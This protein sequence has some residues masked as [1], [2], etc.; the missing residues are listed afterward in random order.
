M[1]FDFEEVNGYSHIHG[2]D[3]THV[4]DVRTDTITKP[5]A[6]MRTAMAVA[7]VGDSVFGEDPTVNELE[8]RCA[9]LLGKEDAVYLPSGTMCNLIAIMVH[10]NKRGVEFIAGDK[11]HT[12]LFEQG[13][14]A[15]L[16][17]VQC[18]LIPNNPDGTFSLQEVE[19]RIRINTDYHEPS[20]ALI[21]V[22]NTQNMCG[23]R[24]LPLEWLDSLAKIAA[25]Y[26]VPIHMDGA[27]LM[28]AVVQSKISAKRI[29]RDMD[30][31]FFC[32]SKGLGCPMGSVL[33]G[34]KGFIH[35]AK[36]FRKMLGGGV[37]QVGILAAA[38]LVALDEMIDRLQIDHDHAYQIAKAIDDLDSDIIRVDLESVQTNIVIIH[39][40]KRTITAKTFL[41]KLATVSETD[42]IK[43]S[44][45]A[46]AFNVSRVRL[47]LHWAITN[48]DVAEAIRKIR[49]V[50]KKIHS[51]L[52]IK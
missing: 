42:D 25:N 43:V 50:I 32:L 31:V 2:T 26:G 47:V 20:T 8:R 22:E 46:S 27:R 6:A 12:H 35:Q 16:A 21:I 7:E 14:P 37:R 5:T 19:S 4:V 30:S 44:V 36:R 10:C 34:N 51:E 15:V 3:M 33:C 52:H 1:P 49:L 48:H 29:A 41:E 28:H 38:G 13:G 11:S 9:D 39:L 40:D 24:V 17:G 23:G 18:S 45:K